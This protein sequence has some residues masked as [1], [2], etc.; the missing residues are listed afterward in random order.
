MAI[1]SETVEQAPFSRANEGEGDPIPGAVLVFSA[2]EPMQG[3]FPIE[4]EPLRIGRGNLRGTEL[5]DGFMSRQHSIIAREG[6]RW[7]VTDCG[8]RNGTAV[9]GQRIRGTVSGNHFSVVRAGETLVLLCTDVRPFQQH[10]IE[11]KDRG[12]IG[13]RSRPLFDKLRRAAATG[14]VHITGET[15]SGKEIAARAFHD[16]GPNPSGPFVAV[17]CA[18]IPEGLAERLLFGA[19]KGAFSGASADVAG[20]VQEA[21]GGTLFLDEVGELDLSVQAKLLR[22][23]E[24]K[25]VLA[26][27]ASKALAVDIRVCSATHKDLR[28]AVNDQ[29][30]RQDLYYRIGR[31]AVELLPLRQRREELPFFLDLQFRKLSPDLQAHASFVEAC[32]LRPW[33]GN[34]RELFVE[35]RESGHAALDAGE[36]EVRASRL[37]PGAGMRSTEEA[38]TVVASSRANRVPEREEVERALAACHGRVATAAR[39]L[40]IHRNQ[41]RR[42][43]EKND[44]NPQDFA[45]DTTP[46]AAD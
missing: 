35:A 31:P 30:F 1:Q 26:L 14:N 21:D 23:L 25:E 17:N 16:Y 6:D 18:A 28:N 45:H 42:W 10:H 29:S 11:V 24:T 20:Y 44:V 22:V 5:R 37:A 36:N 3:V 4:D 19:K 34:V 33:P 43:L 13:P 12:I 8:S 2:G 27:G 39:Q 41:L 15:G 38:D 32:L 7:S 40:G 9:D 46:T